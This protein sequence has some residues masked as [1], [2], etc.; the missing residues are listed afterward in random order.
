MKII[1]SL[2]NNAV[3]SLISENLV[4]LSKFSE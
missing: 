1:V 4:N 2:A 3:N